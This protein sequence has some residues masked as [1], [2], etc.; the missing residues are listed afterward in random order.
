MEDE[1]MSFCQNC[2]TELNDNAKF[3]ANCGNTVTPVGTPTNNTADPRDILGKRL[4]IYSIILFV[5][6]ALQI[7]TILLLP[8]GICYLFLGLTWLE[9]SKDALKSKKRLIWLE[10]HTRTSNVICVFI[11]HFFIGGIV[12]IGIFIYYYIAIT[13]YLRENSA[14]FEL[15]DQAKE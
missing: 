13:C 14:L 12:G 6:G 10:A 3:C 7:L 9:A 4:K 2:G 15:I 11:T 5:F 8:L 1:I